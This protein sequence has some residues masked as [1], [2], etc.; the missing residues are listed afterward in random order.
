MP[1]G[2]WGAGGVNQVWMNP[3]TS[4][5]YTQIYSAELYTRKVCTA[6]LWRDSAMG[7]RI[8]QQLCRELLL[9]ESS[10]W[11][12]LITTGS[13]RDYAEMRFLTHNDLFNELKRIWNAFESRGAITEHQ[14]QRLAEIELRDSI[15]PDID[16][17]LWMSGA[18]QTMPSPPLV[19]G[20]P[21]DQQITPLRAGPEVESSASPVPILSAPAST[22]A[23]LPP[24]W[25]KITPAC[26]DSCSA[27]QPHEP[28][29][30][31]PAHS[32]K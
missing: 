28:E 27:A 2:S 22:V 12:F 23:E 20:P 8:M 29:S 10:D 25:H 7:K 6:G 14:L 16:P 18:K 11:Q 5:T 19:Q 15:F 9:L 3:E 21:S 30:A 26:E 24:C 4:W 13:A 1:E 32:S 31:T 17:S